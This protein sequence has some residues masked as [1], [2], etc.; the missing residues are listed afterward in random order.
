MNK[1]SIN[2]NLNIF[3][4]LILLGFSFL[5]IIRCTKIDSPNEK[6]PLLKD[7]IKTEE[8]KLDLK[9]RLNKEIE[10][11]EKDLDLSK[12]V[13]SMDGITLV[14]A[15]YK[16]YSSIIKEGKESDKPE[17]QELANKLEKK[18][19]NSQIK[20][21]PKLRMIYY[22]LIRE[23]LWENDIDV[24]ILNSSNKTLQLTG[25]IFASNKNIQD[26]QS[27]L[28]EVLSLLRFKQIQYKWYSGDD[29]FTYYNLDSP[30]DSEIID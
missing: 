14:L 9:V 18:V 11:L 26:T 1:A 3:K 7:S 10:S 21:L 4:I 29:E 30:K 8:K 20:V 15:L 19:I 5:S 6:S 13:S 2:S 12:N 28:H 23:K 16:F 25:G 22:K 24:K 27:M 17:E